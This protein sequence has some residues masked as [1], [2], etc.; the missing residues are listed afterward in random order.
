MTQPTLFPGGVI[1]IFAKAPVA[2]EVKTRLIPTLG[3]QGAARL[4]EQLARRCI[5][6]ASAAA[7][8]PV[9]L[10]CAPD[11]AH[12]FFMQCQKEFGVTLHTQQ[13]GDLGARMAHALSTALETA[14]YTIIIGTDC[15]ALT[16]HDLREALAM[17]EQGYDAVLGPAE[18]GGYVLLGLRRVA[19]QPFENIPWGTE[20]V[21][22]LTR[23]RLKQLQWRWHELP[24]RRDIDR[25][26]DLEHPLIQNLLHS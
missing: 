12:P 24:A 4:H 11:A 10:W 16:A 25:P 26:Q 6:Q 23:A 3:A 20:Q 9:Q 8:S 13:G 1:L 22:D 15:P 19:P 21:L 17:L 14:S 2:G 7:L 18:D 5:A